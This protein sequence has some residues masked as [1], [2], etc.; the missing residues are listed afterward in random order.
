MPLFRKHQVRLLLTGHEHLFEHWV[1]RW[2]DAQGSWRMD[3]IVSG[4]GGAQLYGWQGEPAL[5]AYQRA[6]SA[7][8]LS[9][10]HLVRPGIEPGL[11]PYHYLVV[12]IDGAR[13]SV[14]VIGVEWGR[15]FAPYRTARTALGDPA[16]VP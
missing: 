7:A 9:V 15:G 3:Q 14:E 4:G 8:T 10:E 1:E 12:T 13:V 5:G 6:D 16:G 11:N 2:T